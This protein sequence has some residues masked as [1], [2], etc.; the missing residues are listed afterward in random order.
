MAFKSQVKQSKPPC[1]MPHTNAETSEWNKKGIRN[2][3]LINTVTFRFDLI[4]SGPSVQV[5]ISNTINHDE[6]KPF[7]MGHVPGS[8]SVKGYIVSEQPR[9]SLF[10]S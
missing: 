3:Q 4:I 2:R 10:A 1:C 7:C 8:S 6:K 9:V 5:P